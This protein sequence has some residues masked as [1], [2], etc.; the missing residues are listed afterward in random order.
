[1]IRI[2]QTFIFSCFVVCAISGPVSRKQALVLARDF[3]A[4]GDNLSMQKVKASGDRCRLTGETAAAFIV[5]RGMSFVLIGRD[6]TQPSVLG[7]GYADGEIPGNLRVMLGGSVSSGTLRPRQTTVV[8]PL[9]STVRHQRA[10]YNNMCPYYTEGNSTSSERTVVG[11]VATAAEEVVSYYRRTVELCDTLHGWTTEYYT[12]ADALP[13]E[14]VDCRLIADNYDVGQHSPASVEAVARLSLWCGMAAR[15]N[16]GLSE[17]GARISRLAEPFRRVLGYGYVRYC[18]SYNYAPEVWRQILDGELDAGRPV[19]YAGYTQHVGGHA[20]VVDGRDADGL[21]H[22]NW[23]Y[24][25]NYDGYFRLDVLCPFEPTD[26]YTPS[27]VA[28]S[29]FCNQEMMLLHPDAQS[30]TLP[31]TLVR[32]GRE[33][34]V[35]DLRFLLAPEAGMYTPLSLS[36]HNSGD[37]T[38]TTP[39]ELFTNLP[40]D[41]ALLAQADFVATTG[42]TLSPG[43]DTTLVVHA[44][45]NRPGHRVLRISPDDQTMLGAFTVDIA[46]HVGNSAIACSRAGTEI[47]GDTLYVRATFSNRGNARFG[48]LLTH[49]LHEGSAAATVA[50]RIH[51]TYTYVSAGGQSEEVIR[52]LHLGRGKTY[53]VTGILYGRNLYELTFT[54]PESTGISDTVS[55]GAVLAERWFTLDGRP[56]EKPRSPGIYIRRNGAGIRK[57]CVPAVS[58]RSH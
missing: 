3:F 8:E 4:T 7:Y 6:D 12:I 39:F 33:V 23:G 34:S 58:V 15:M 31:D 47:R 43:A 29:F 1:M 13:G 14:T 2:F 30:V 44:F 22:V 11:C 40:S 24:G 16:Y 55:G 10:P 56:V 49:A 45:F 20:F 51:Y 21:Y 48:K 17:S 54:V 46:E 41:T 50:P 26:D 5:E 52:F 37:R 36:L 38:L 27:S 18:D 25:G 35:T 42:V 19:L 53:T 28:A 32:D 9:L 57:V